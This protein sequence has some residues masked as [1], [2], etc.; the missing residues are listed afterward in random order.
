MVR[1]GPNYNGPR[2]PWDN[3]LPYG[4]PSPPLRRICSICGK[5]YVKIEGEGSPC[6]HVR[7]DGTTINPEPGELET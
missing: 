7:A 6:G 4:A 3:E 5:R 2:L 1:K